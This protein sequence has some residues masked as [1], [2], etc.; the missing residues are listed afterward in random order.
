MWRAAHIE[1]SLSFVEI[2]LWVWWEV[3]SACLV[4]CHA[5]LRTTALFVLR[6]FPVSGGRR[7]GM[8][9]FPGM[10][11][12][13]GSRTRAPPYAYRRGSYPRDH[14]G[15][16]FRL[17][18][19]SVFQERT[20]FPPR[21]QPVHPWKTHPV[22]IRCSIKNRKIQP[23]WPLG[24]QWIYSEKGILST[25]WVKCFLHRLLGTDAEETFSL[26]KRL[27]FVKTG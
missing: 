19:C 9:L 3:V 23:A 4:G 16:S 2:W 24:E 5:C 14:A 25:P 10:A 22:L 17:N 13:P 8:G 18:C 1:I 27:S 21:K 20:M 26:G 15:L 12:L 11:S 7:A 6:H